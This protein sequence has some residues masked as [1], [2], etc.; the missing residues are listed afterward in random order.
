MQKKVLSEVDLYYGN[1]DMPKGFEI[2]TD[3]LKNQIL[4][5]FIE[6]KRISNN[7]KDYAYSDFKIEPT[8]TL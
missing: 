6:E 5:S 4:N 8:P 2:K 3:V 1:I 7:I